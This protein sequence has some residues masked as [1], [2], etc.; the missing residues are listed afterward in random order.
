MSRTPPQRH[1]LKTGETAVVRTAELGDA[2]AVLAVAA[3]ITEDTAF[4]ISLPGEF[5]MTVDQEKVW[6]ENHLNSPGNLALVA[7]V[8]GSIAGVLNFQSG[9][10]RR[11]A[12]QGT[13]GVRVLEEWR[14]RGIGRGLIVTLLDWATDS[15]RVEKVCL[16]VFAT[17]DRAIALYRGLGFREEGR[18]SK[19]IK[20]G[21]D[22]YVDDILMSKFVK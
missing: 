7:E 21:P 8:S 13:F 5:N 10:R 6:L 15:P 20:L 18:R 22:E 11:V 9:S 2:A 4:T 3:S 19:S 14:D 16:E 1:E 12:H 17:N